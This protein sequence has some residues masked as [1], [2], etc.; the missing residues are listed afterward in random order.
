[1][2]PKKIALACDHAGWTL[3]A[4]LIKL[5]KKAGGFCVDMS[6]KTQ[7]PGDDYPAYAGKVARAVASNKADLGVLCC[8][9]GIGVCIAANKIR[10]I[11]AAVAWNPQS[12]RLAREHNAANV[13]CLGG[14]LLS[15]AQ[16]QACLTAFLEAVPSA[17]MRHARRIKK[18]HRLERCR[19]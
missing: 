18:I 19:L 14:R 5:I 8:G 16:A 1:M 15:A 4:S 3:K 11:R 17:E 10:G 2:K 12:A 9:S 6:P 7:R 13:L